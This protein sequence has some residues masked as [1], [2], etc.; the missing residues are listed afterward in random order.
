MDILAMW[1]GLACGLGVNL[2]LIPHF[3]KIKPFHP[4]QEA[5]VVTERWLPV[6]YDYFWTIS[7]MIG[8]LII[9]FTIA[10]QGSGFNYF[11]LGFFSM[12]TTLL[13]LVF[14][15]KFLQQIRPVFSGDYF[16]DIDYHFD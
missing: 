2:L 1:L 3:N 14:Y 8:S 9:T 6:V 15:I 4:Q 12:V 10:T 11:F 7:L 5:P 16:Q 13:A